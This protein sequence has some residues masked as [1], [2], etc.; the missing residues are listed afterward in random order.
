ML[1]DRYT[2][3]LP[4]ADALLAAYHERLQAVDPTVGSAAALNLADAAAVLA[5]APEHPPAETIIA[6]VRDHLLLLMTLAVV[7]VDTLA[8]SID[9][10]LTGQEVQQAIEGRSR[11]PLTTLAE[12]QFALERRA[13]R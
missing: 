11:L 9:A 2:A 6:E 12:L 4:D 3:E 1:V 5:A 13:A 10:D 7:D 8:G